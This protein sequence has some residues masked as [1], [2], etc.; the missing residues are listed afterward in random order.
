MVRLDLSWYD[1]FVVDLAYWPGDVLKNL[2]MAV[3]ATAV[4]RAFPD[5]LPRRRT[6]PSPAE[7]PTHTTA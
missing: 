1:A 3:V 2:A 7:N 5:L 6:A 4:H